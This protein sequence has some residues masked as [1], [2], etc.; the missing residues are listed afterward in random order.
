MLLY[1]RGLTI[2]I[3]DIGTR[4]G[5]ICDSVIGMIVQCGACW[6]VRRR[7]PGHSSAWSM[8]ERLYRTYL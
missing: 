3:K 2:L 5:F 6:P 7:R 1:V 4:E 8:A